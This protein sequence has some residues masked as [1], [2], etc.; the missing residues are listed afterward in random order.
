MTQSLEMSDKISEEKAYRLEEA[1]M[2]FGLITKGLTKSE[3]IDKM[4]I[5]NYQFYRICS[6]KA[7]LTLLTSEE[8]KK[9][10]LFE[11]AEIE[12]DLFQALDVLKHEFDK[13][14]PHELAALN[15][16]IDKLKIR[17][18]EFLLG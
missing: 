10:K 13:L 6:T 15:N 7:F 5:S 1:T 9:P 14:A 16:R 8:R 11:I 18:A 17:Y 4:K 2:V 12:N 3:I